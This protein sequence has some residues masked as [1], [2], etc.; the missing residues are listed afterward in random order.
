M[1][2]GPTD[3]DAPDEEYPRTRPKSRAYKVQL[4]GIAILSCNDENNRNVRTEWRRTDGRSLPYGSQLYN[5]KL[6]IDEIQHD[7]SGLYEC[8]AYDGS[9][10]PFTIDIAELIIT[11]PPSITFSPS[12]PMVVR[13]GDNVLIQCIATGE[14]PIEVRWHG[15]DGSPLPRFVT[16]SNFCHFP[17]AIS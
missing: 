15:G 1:I 4:G 12:M 6:T 10:E 5:G 14:E 11:E 13:N 9:I 3:Y 7:A 16:T 17:T 2:P 8:I